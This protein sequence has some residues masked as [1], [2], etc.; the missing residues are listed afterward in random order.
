VPN[1]VPRLEHLEALGTRIALNSNT[2]RHLSTA[3]KLQA[4]SIRIIDDLS[5]ITFEQNS[6]PA[7]E[8]LDV[9]GTF[10]DCTQLLAGSRTT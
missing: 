4:L 2:V 9:I 7:L 1:L 8:T 6:F 5:S 10:A 3:R